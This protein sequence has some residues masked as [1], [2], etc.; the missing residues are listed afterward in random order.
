QYLDAAAAE[1][2]ASGL[3]PEEARR[4]VR[5]DL[6]SLTVVREQVRGYGWENV[7]ETLI[8]DVRYGLRR[9]RL[10]PAFT[11]VGAIT[12]ALGIG[13]STA[14]FSAVNPVLF[15]PLPYP[16]AG[17][18]M[19]IWDGQN[20]TRFDVTFGTYRELLARNR[21]FESMAAM[22]P[23]LPTLTGVEE[24]ERLNGQLVSADYFRVLGVRPAL[25]RDF[26]AADDVP[27]QP[28]GPVVAIISDTLWRRRFSADPALV[29][30]QILLNDIPTTVIG[31]MP[32]GFENVLSPEA[33]IW[34]TLRYDPALPLNGREWGHHLRMVGRLRPDGHVGLARQELNAIARNTLAEFP[35]PS[36]ATLPEG[37]IADPLQDDLTHGVR[38][39][40]LAI[41]GGVILLLTIA[42]VNTTNLLLARGAERRT[43]LIMRAALG[44]SRSRIIRQ[45]LVETVMLAVLGGGLGIILA[46]VAVDALVALSPADLPRIDAIE[47]DNQALLFAVTLTTIIGLLVGMAPA[48]Q[49]SRASV[50][51]GR[52]RPES[53]RVAGGHQVTRRTL[54]VVQVALAL[55]LLVAAGLLVRSLNRLF[56]IPPGFDSR[57][58]LTMQVQTA[59]RRYGD[60]ETAHR[61]FNRVIDEVQ[62]VP[63][64]SAAAFTSQLPLTG[65]EDVWGVHFESVPTAAADESRDGYRYAVSPRYFAAMG[66][67]LR[68]GRL[69]DERDTADAPLAVVINESFARRRLPGVNPIGQRL[70]IGP[71]NSPPFTV[72]GVVADVTQMSLAMTRSDAVYMV[73]AQWRFADLARWLVVRTKGDAASLTAGVRRAIAS[74]DS[75]QPVLRVA[76]MDERLRASAADRRFALLLFEAFGLTAMLLAAVG[77]YSLLS[78]SVTERTREIGV[79]SALGATR[80]RIVGLVLRQGMTLTAI[81]ITIGLAG[82]FIAS[83]ALVTLLFGISPLDAVTYVAVAG[84]L[85]GVSLIACGMPAWRAARVHPSIALRFE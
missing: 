31:I 67:P 58:V 53:S 64:V 75:D 27:F 44:A 74:V 80:F 61:F 52:S 55:V 47:V 62:K 7:V 26:E 20:G 83:R 71:E 65:D 5:R 43:E 24:P 51:G 72:V 54:V 77:T 11:I 25:G 28:N 18:L 45:L 78:G 4:Q 57:N 66:I 70:R 9:L 22:R 8:A 35:R 21:S 56:A 81:G 15:Q 73:A 19:M 37:F 6:G 82:A 10:N 1:L 48:M 38:P 13:A 39:A 84:L 85:A 32:R 63:G 59:G 36:W 40:L 29:G 12:L 46:H 50:Q 42:C 76:T 68:A 49:G 3:S 41:S 69:L 2:E 79:R 60:A 17:R 23:A 16:D 34:S 30:R 14:I 33:E